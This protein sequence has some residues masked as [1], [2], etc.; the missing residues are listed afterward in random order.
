M[1]RIKVNSLRYDETGTLLSRPL[2]LTYMHTQA[3]TKNTHT[4]TYTHRH[5][6]IHTHTHTYGWGLPFVI[7]NVP[8]VPVGTPTSACWETTEST[9]KQ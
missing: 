3:R 5:S 9:T 7:V 4:H 6:H 8:S 1:L 2:T